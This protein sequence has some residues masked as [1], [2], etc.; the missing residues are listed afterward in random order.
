MEVTKSL[1]TRR[2]GT[3][4]EHHGT[5]LLLII[6]VSCIATSIKFRTLAAANRKDSRIGERGRV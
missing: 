5:P 4:V 3:L 6:Y 1:G 2:V